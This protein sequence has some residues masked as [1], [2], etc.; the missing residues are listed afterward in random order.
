[1]VITRAPLAERVPVEPA[2]MP[3][4]VVVQWDKDA[5]EEAGLIKIDI[6]GLRMLSAI[7]EAVA[8]IAQTTGQGVDLDHLTFDDPQVYAMIARADTIGMFQ[9]ESRAQAQVLPQLKP[10]MFGDLIIAISLIRPGPLQ[11]DMVHPYLRRRQGLERVRYLHPLLKPA[12][13]ET[14]GVILFQEQTLKVA[15]DL[16]GF[17]AGRGEQ[18]RR[19]LGSKH[20]DA[21]IEALRAAFL[22]GAAAKGVPIAVA[23]AVFEQLRAF[24]S[25]SFPKSHA[26]AFAV[27]VYQSAWLKRYH[28]AALFCGLLN[29]QP[30]GF[31]PP[32]VLIGDAR[33]H[34]VTILPPDV[35]AS[36][37][38]C[39][40]EG[41]GIRLGL[42]YVNGLGTVAIERIIAVRP[43][44]GMAN[45]CRRTKLPR[46]LIERLIAAG[47]LDT[48]G[49]ARRQLLWELGTLHYAADELV[50]SYQ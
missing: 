30:M 31:W 9:V 4:R 11:G 20:A 47:A 24:G 32:S 34:G 5:L 2:A 6:L 10:R 38:C 42:S 23:T 15:R 35:H 41:G 18:L 22:D 50:L 27:I 36:A 37:A 14:L 3:G 16:A 33:R 7:S 13:E 43:F 1:M 17:T 8:L 49:I 29:A 39:T 25:Y 44:A 21:A 28:P 40:L 26:A 45:L 46:A 12:L 19:A 48:W